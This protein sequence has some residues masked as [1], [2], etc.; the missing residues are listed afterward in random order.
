MRAARFVGERSHEQK[1]EAEAEQQHGAKTH[2][3]RLDAD[4]NSQHPT[5]S[6]GSSIGIALRRRQ[7]RRLGPTRLTGESA[8]LRGMHAC[9]VYL[10]IYIILRI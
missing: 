7:P 4:P 6:E 3:P 2:R 9:A 1:T 8:N 5:F 10:Y